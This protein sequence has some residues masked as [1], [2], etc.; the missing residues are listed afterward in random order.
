MSLDFSVIKLLVVANALTFLAS[1]HCIKGKGIPYPS[2]CI[3]MAAR[4]NLKTPNGNF[5]IKTRQLES[6]IRIYSVNHLQ[7]K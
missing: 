6:V 5:K 3:K 7:S 1:A 2:G 4:R